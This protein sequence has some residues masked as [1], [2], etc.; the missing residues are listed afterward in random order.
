M[1]VDAKTKRQFD[2]IGKDVVE[3]IRHTTRDPSATIEGYKAVR[4]HL[5]NVIEAA[6]QELKQLEDLKN[7]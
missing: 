2:K 7:G 3:Y 6:E 1:A 4:E 5:D